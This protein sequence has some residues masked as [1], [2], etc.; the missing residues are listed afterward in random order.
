MQRKQ[1]K[2]KSFFFYDFVK[3]TG[4][5][6]AFLYLLPRIHYPW[7]KPSV[8]GSVLVI[9]N[10]SSLWDPVILLFTFLSRRPIFVAT[11]DLFSSKLSRW[12]FEH[13][14]C[15]EINKENFSISTFHKVRTELIDGSMVGVFPEGRVHEGI[16]K[17]DNFK[18]GAV[19]MAV[20]GKSDIIPVYVKQR[21]HWPQR[22]EIFVGN[23]IANPGFE[24]IPAMADIETF[25]NKLYGIECD[26][27]NCCDNE[28]KQTK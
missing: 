17:L 10:H 11:T 28:G 8:K 25:S 27:K 1:S 13:V 12:F 21:D 20:Q 9:C 18:G 6:P 15:I 4:M 24:S 22:T 23:R 2:H 19:M 14:H 5:L 26:L 3:V 16:D 7:G